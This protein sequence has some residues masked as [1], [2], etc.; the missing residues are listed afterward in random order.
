MVIRKDVPADMRADMLKLFT[1]LPRIDRTAAIRLADSCTG[2]ASEPRFAHVLDLL[3]LFL[4]RAAR[5]GLMGEPAAQG[6][7][8]RW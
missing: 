1:G 5:A 7:T 8:A 4:S 3:D 6:A 2:R